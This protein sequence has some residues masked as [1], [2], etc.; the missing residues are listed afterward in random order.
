[1]VMMMMMLLLWSLL[2]LLVVVVVTYA[3]LL[4]QC[5]KVATLSKTMIDSTRRLV[6]GFVSPRWIHSLGAKS[7]PLSD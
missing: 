3:S 7:I 2:L 6:L 1:M 4:V 5:C